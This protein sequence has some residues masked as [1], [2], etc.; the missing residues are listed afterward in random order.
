MIPYSH[1]S[2]MDSS[3]MMVLI[4]NLLIVLL[5]L[6]VPELCTESKGLSESSLKP[7]NKIFYQPRISTVVRHFW[8]LL[9]EELQHM[10][11]LEKEVPL[12]K[13][14][15]PKKL[16][17]SLLQVPHCKYSKKD[18]SHKLSGMLWVAKPNML[19]QSYQD[20]LRISHLVFSVFHLSKATST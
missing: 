7:F 2:K 5:R 20:S 3:A 15:I 4:K 11:G 19:P 8:S 13:L 6:L 14:L 18:R 9:R 1:S 10:L 12:K 17:V 16:L